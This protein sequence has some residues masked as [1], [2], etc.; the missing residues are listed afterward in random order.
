VIGDGP[1]INQSQKLRYTEQLEKEATIEEWL[2]GSRNP[3]EFVS[4]L[5]EVNIYC[6]R[7][8]HALQDQTSYEVSPCEAD[9]D[10]NNMPGIQGPT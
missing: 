9:H 3:I 7:G 2:D 6:D 5:S 8:T 4:I 10:I 1:G